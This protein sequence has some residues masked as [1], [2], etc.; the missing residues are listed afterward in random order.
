MTKRF[1]RVFAIILV[2]GTLSTVGMAAKKVPKPKQIVAFMDDTMRTPAQGQAQ[3]CEEYKKMTGIELKIIQPVHNQYYEKLRLAFAAGDIPDVVEISE[4]NYVQFANEGALV[5]LGKYIRTSSLKK[6]ARVLEGAKVNGKIYGIPREAPNGPITYIRQDWLNNLGLKVPTTWAEY[7]NVMK[8]FTQKD[9]DKNGKND[10]FGV[11]APGPSGDVPI[12]LAD[13]YYR[14]FYQNASPTFILR[15]GKW[16]DGFSQKEMK[17]ALERLRKVYQEKLIDPEIFTNKTSTCREKFTSGKA[18]MFAYWAGMFNVRLETDLQKNLGP[19]AKITPIPS[20]KGSHYLARVPSVN[21]ITTKAKNPEGIFKYFI[22]FSHDGNKGQMLFT[23]GVEGVHWSVKDGKKVQLPSLDN[24]ALPNPK[25]Y[26]DPALQIVPWVNGKA[27]IELD[28]RIENSRKLFAGKYTN[29]VFQVFTDSR[30]RI[31]DPLNNAK[32][33]ALVKSIT[34]SKTVDQA[35][36]DYRKRYMEL[37][38]DHVLEDIN[39]L[40][41]K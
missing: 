29:D 8:A 9:P 27:P 12:T 14:D 41:K 5:D 34:G 36:A 40:T 30:R 20:L 33:E 16:I 11:T 32:N 7:Y 19:A 31:E 17:P 28:E 24:P 15:R 13:N 26:N 21:A 18:G 22:E 25:S 10:T 35:L 4:S 3:I 1:F 6:V 39:A 38:V 2:L 23:H 37:K